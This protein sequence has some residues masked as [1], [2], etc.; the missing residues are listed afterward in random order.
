V[1]RG[2]ICEVVTILHG[3]KLL[4]DEVKVTVEEVLVL[5]TLVLVP[6]NKIYNVAHA[7]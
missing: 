7:F 4:E 2:T 6:T 5:D 1:A 3:M